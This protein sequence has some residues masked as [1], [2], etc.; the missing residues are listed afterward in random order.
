MRADIIMKECTV[1][2]LAAAT[3]KPGTTLIDVREYAEY[4][5]GRVAGSKL[6]PLGEIDIRHGEINR[7]EEIYLICRSGVRS[8]KAQLKLNELG[9][10][11]TANVV[12]GFE[13]WRQAGLPIEKD[14]RAVWDLE[15]Q[16]R[17]T[18]GSLVLIGVVL[19]V[20]VNLYL[21][22]LSGF[23]GAG[24]IFSAVT[25]TCTMGLLLSKMPWNRPN[26]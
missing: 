21:I 24:L 15:R 19:A 16:I 22:L 6:M 1:K 4:A 7:D 8:R 5:A 3:G 13:A 25:N 17:F 12:G 2:Q 20:T 18:A 26:V 9:I 14:E 11:N 23:I 10:T